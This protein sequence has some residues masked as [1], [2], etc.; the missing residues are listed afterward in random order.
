METR[1]IFMKIDEYLFGFPKYL[2]ND[3]EGLMFFYP[4]K[5]PPIVAFYE[6]LAKKIGTDPKAYQEYGNKAHDELFKGFG[7][8][9]EEYKKGD[10]T[11]LEFLV[12]TDMRCHKL[13]CYRFWPVNYL[14]ADG[15]LHDFYVDNLR[16]LIRK[17]IDATEDV[18]DFEGRVVRVQRDLLQSDYADLYLRQA[19]E[20]TS[21]MEIM[22]K[23]PKIS[24]LFPAVTKLIDEHEHKNTAEINKVWEQVYEIIKNDKDPDLKKAMWLPMEQVKMRG[25]MLP[26]YNMLTH[27]VEFR[28]EN[29]RLTERHNDMARKIEEYKK[30]AQQKLSQEDYELF[31]LCYEQSRNFSMYKDVMGELDAPLLPMWFGIHKKIKDILVKDTPIKPRPTG[32]TAVV[33]HLIWYLPDNLK[34]KVMTPD[35]TPFSLETL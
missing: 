22:Q 5:F 23:H 3:L 8:I 20:G 21:A 4:E 14:F 18:E 2:P 33:H 12:N 29:K 24:T 11:S 15:P 10:Q 25:T 35:F 32:P 34:A 26:L 13:F 30:L 7:K 9:N 16:N 6:D 19:L 31:L 1:G 27:T 28:E 17:F